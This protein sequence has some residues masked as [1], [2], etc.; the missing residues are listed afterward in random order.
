MKNYLL[1]ASFALAIF[2]AGFQSQAQNATNVWESVSSDRTQSL[3]KETR[4]AEPSNYDLFRLNTAN[5]K[6]MLS[7]AP[8][9]DQLATSQVIIQLPTLNGEMQSFRVVEAPTFT[10]GLQAQF[11][12]IRSYAAQGIDDPTAIARFSVSPLGLNAMISSANHETTYIDPYTRNKEFYI[13]YSR[14]SMPADSNTFECLVEDSNEPTIDY[15]AVAALKNADDGKL[16]TFRLALACTGEYATYHLN[17]QGIP[18]TATDA[19]KKAAVLSAMNT[20]MTRVNG[21]YERDL[22]VTMVIVPNNTDIIFLNAATDPYTNNDGAVMLNQNQTTCNNIIGSANYDIGHVFSTGGGGIAQLNSPCTAS[23]KAR[24][25]TG[26]PA[27]IGDF[28]DVDYVAHE[29]GHQFGGNHTQNNNCQRSSASVEPGSASTIMGY[30]GI[31]A[32]NVQTHS[33]DYFNGINILEMWNNISVGNSTCGVQTNTGNNPPTA[34]AGDNFTIPKSTPFVLKGIASD[35]DATNTLSY[36]WEQ[37][38]NQAAAMP[39]QPTST[40]GPAFRSLPSQ[41]SPDRYMPALPTVL[42]GS[43]QTT[44]EVVPSVSRVMRFR[45]TVRDN[46]AGGSSTAS[47]ITAVSVDDSA[48]PFVVTSQATNITWNAAQ[49]REVT[50]DVAGTDSGTVNSPNVD[51]L[52]SVDGGLNFDITLASGVP[53]NGSANIT[54]P[55]NID[56]TDARLMVASSNNIFYNVNASNFTIDSELSVNDVNFSDLAIYPNPSNGTFKVNFT[57]L[58]TSE[59]AISL[60]DVRGREINTQVFES[61]GAT[62]N[63]TF[64]YSNLVAGM[65]FVTVKNNGLSQTMKVI[66]E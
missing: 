32:P 30:A 48:G 28:F 44:W 34:D 9:R 49:T 36:N 64:N 29:M 51:I 12:E 3:E 35:P 38:D 59:I 31:C 42:L 33:D 37:R 18:T 13:G 65:Y 50:W 15:E 45:F 39:P 6:A 24:G 58:S 17:N 1:K 54:V 57:P 8:S 19:V 23:G 63:E 60:Y 61:T 66:I 20:S 56:T 10:E 27:P 46:A 43:T 21:I 4:K 41:A 25:V 14:S 26:L 52:L 7:E 2:F 62:F 55:S 11:P 16:R 40:V 22:S 47:D 53:N 5:L